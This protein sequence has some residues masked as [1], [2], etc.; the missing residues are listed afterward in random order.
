MSHLGNTQNSYRR[1]CC[2]KENIRPI[3]MTNSFHATSYKRPPSSPITSNPPCTKKI[4]LS[5]NKTSKCT[6]SRIP[7]AYNNIKRALSTPAICQ[8][9]V[10]TSRVELKAVKLISKKYPCL[11]CKCYRVCATKE[12]SSQCS[13]L[14]RGNSEVTC[15]FVQDAIE[16]AQHILNGTSSTAAQFGLFNAES[17]LQLAT[18]GWEELII[19]KESR[20]KERLLSNFEYQSVVVVKDPYFNGGIDNLKGKNFCHPGL[21]YSRSQKWTE[22]FLKEFERFTVTPQCDVIANASVAEIEALSLL[23]YFNTACRPGA[24]SNNMEED[25]YLKR[26]Y[27]SLCA[28]CDDPLKCEYSSSISGSDHRKALE[29]VK[30]NGHV[31]YVSLKDATDFFKDN[32]G[33][34]NEYKYLCP[35]GTI[36]SVNTTSPCTWLNQP[37]PVV[38]THTNKSI[39][40]KS[41][42]TAWS[43]SRIEWQTAVTDILTDRGNHILQ[44]ATIQSPR[45]H[46]A[47]I[48]TLPDETS[49]CD[50][51]INWCTRSVEETEK[52][53]VARAG[54]I[55]TG[56]YPLI[57]CN[58]G[59][60][61]NSAVTCLYEISQGKNDIMGI[62]SNYGYIARNNFNLTAALY[63][64]TD[65]QHY[66]KVVILIKANSRISRFEDLKGKKACFPEFGG[67]ASIAFVD[68]GRGRGL[69][70]QNEC[71]YGR[72]LAGFF[73]DSCA[74]GAKD[75]LRDSKFRQSSPE[76]D[77]LCN[78]CRHQ[79]SES[80]FNA[81][82]NIETIPAGNN[83][84]VRGQM[85]NE[86]ENVAE[87]RPK[88]QVSNHC[89][90]THENRYFGTKGALQCL[91]E[92]GEVAVLELRKLQEFAEEMKL[93]P[94]DY[95]IMCRNGTI[96][97]TNN[98]VVDQNC[99]LITMIDGEVVI[100]RR[101]QKA[102]D[103]VNVL[104]SF[105][106]YFQLN[107]NPDF[108]IFDKFNGVED[109][110]FEDST[111]GLVSAN[112]T[113]FGPSV[114]NYIRLFENTDK[115]VEKKNGSNLAVFS[116]I[117]LTLSVLMTILMQ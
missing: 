77:K 116:S 39:E 89:A 108:K 15:V 96:S 98:F 14:Q 97:S 106:R 52:C 3:S 23:R 43:N 32:A 13:I 34:A 44:D 109:L 54:G 30:K 55:S 58:Q 50:K 117:L 91:H 70:K 81:D 38:M 87:S 6:P 69:F 88:R 101:S 103:V 20:H 94:D 64:E 74:P 2:S 92:V 48:R 114:Q 5:S 78:L 33:T 35:N 67:I 8:K 68:T 59:Y 10:S 26:T 7:K 110:L 16:C 105:D 71:N 12:F 75:V 42:V 104:N 83:A 41:L 37:W 45:K 113:E 63:A 22:R 90:P 28:L 115:C 85:R 65:D 18:L 4:F 62:D 111:I 80:R 51:R 49:I 107:A 36:M 84:N 40:L 24:W 11:N 95:K 1:A 47:G 100:Q 99:P 57:S 112:A 82:E 31:T 27:P 60:P 53:K 86:A 46:L 72:L 76:A 93:N 61:A 56:T 17:V 29:C 19:I 9:N 21:H 79:A 25:Q 73:G 102:K 66:S